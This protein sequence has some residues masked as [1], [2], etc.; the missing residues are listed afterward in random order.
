MREF[1]QRKARKSGAENEPARLPEYG[2]VLIETNPGQVCSPEA[3]SKHMRKPAS[4][5]CLHDSRLQNIHMQ[6]MQYDCKDDGPRRPLSTL[7]QP[8]SWGLKQG[9]S[10]VCKAEV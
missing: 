10:T 5:L 6:A 2:S 7:S 1:A 4:S 9:A 8:M 3:T